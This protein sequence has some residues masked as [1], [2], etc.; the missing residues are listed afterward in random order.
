MEQ[1]RHQHG[2]NLRRLSEISGLA[3]EEICDF[4]ANLNPLGP[5]RWLRAVISANIGTLAAYP[6]PDCHELGAAI[7]RH[8]QVEQSEVL[9]ANGASELLY[10]L[11]RVLNKRHALIPVPAYADYQHPAA[12][13]GMEITLLP[14]SAADGFRLDMA[15]LEA[16]LRPDQIVFIGQPNNPTGVCNDSAALRQLALDH[17]QTVFIIDESFI[18]FVTNAASLRQRRPA[19]VVV[20]QSLTKSYAIAGLRLGYAIADKTV[21][22]ALRAAQPEW[23]VNTLAQAVGIRALADADYLANSRAFIAAQRQQ[24]YQLLN[25]IPA[26][27]LFDSSANFILARLEH[28]RLDVAQLAAATLQHGIA[29]RECVNFAGLDKRYLRL[30]VRNSAE[31]QRLAHVL[32]TILSPRQRRSVRSK[33]TPALMIQGTTSN[34][35]KSVLAAALCRV[36]YQ[37]GVDVAPFKAQNMSLNSFV[38]RCG[39]EMGR[40]QAMQAQACG[41]EPDVRMNPILLKPN[42]DTGSQVIVRGKVHASMDF[43]AYTRLRPQ[44]FDTVKATY[45]ELAAEHQAMVLEGAGSPAEVNLKKYDIVNMNMARYAAAPVLICGDIDR[46]GVFA[47]FVGTM[48]L[49][50]EAERELVAGF[51]VNRF[52]GDATLLGDAFE[53]TREHTGKP[54]LGTVPYLTNLGLPEE[55]SVTF[56]ERASNT[57]APADK[58]DIAVIDLPHISNFTDLDA[59]AI[60]PDVHLRIVRHAAELGRPDAIIIPGSKNVAADLA[61][62]CSDELG[63]AITACAHGTCTIV[64]ICGGFQMLGTSIADPA[65]VETTTQHS[66]ALGL[67]DIS[68]VLAAQ[69]TTLQSRCRHHPSGLELIGYEIHHGITSVGAVEQIISNSAGEMVGAASGDGKIWGTY[70]HGVFDSDP[71]R[72]WFI[73]SLRAGRGWTYDGVIRARYNLEPAFDRLADCLRAAVDMDTIYRLMG[74]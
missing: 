16:A 46:G 21:I 58:I 73:D 72:R 5:P 19:N 1:L 42:S 24:L 8:N 63:A 51:I 27:H 37:D 14:T 15:Q 41:L 40:A 68:T 60:E 31:Q 6:D 62:L 25:E 22:S 57:A 59:L 2:G 33:K 10:L 28:P 32:K 56:K 7:A 44:L 17:P 12:L 34:A 67:L 30:A 29:I 39:G 74:L 47:A 20:V 13:S 48:E 36:L 69:K 70:L 53:R 65:A 50:S 35:G 3:P 71:F 9:V 54:V 18:D 43:R 38:A 23:S 4:S 61:H 55:D 49:L 52:R 26:L 64:G 11:P 66:S 45:T